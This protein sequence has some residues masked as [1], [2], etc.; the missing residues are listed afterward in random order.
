MSKRVC[1]G[2]MIGVFT[3]VCLAGM[4]SLQAQVEQTDI[5]GVWDMEIDADGEY[6]YLTMTVKKGEKGLQAFVSEA[7]G[8]FTDITVSELKYEGENLSFVIVVPTPPDGAERRVDFALVVS[9]ESMSGTI[10]ITDLQMI[11]DVTCTKQK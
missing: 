10:N 9:G 3:L 6:Y 7:N 1:T 4:S 2:L 5:T 8:M 11:A